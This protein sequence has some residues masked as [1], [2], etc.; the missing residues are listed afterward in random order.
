MAIWLCEPR[1]S[2]DGET[3]IAKALKAAYFEAILSSR[4]RL[5]RSVA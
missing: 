1:L 4:S 3:L 5:A 2:R